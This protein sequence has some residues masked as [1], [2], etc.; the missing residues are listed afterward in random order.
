MCGFRGMGPFK[1]MIREPENGVIGMWQGL[2]RIK[3]V[4]MSR[5]YRSQSLGMA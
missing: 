4:I 3:A 1:E 2:P 5:V